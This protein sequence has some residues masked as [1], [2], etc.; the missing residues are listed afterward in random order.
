LVSPDLRT[1]Y[2][3]WKVEDHRLV[4]EASALPAPVGRRVR[5]LFQVGGQIYVY[6]GVVAPG[7]DV[8]VTIQGQQVSLILLLTQGYH[9]QLRRNRILP[10]GP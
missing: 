6:S 2:G 7:G 10:E 8:W 5:L 1:V 9:L 4:A 3:V